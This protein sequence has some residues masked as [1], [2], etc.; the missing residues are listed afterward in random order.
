MSYQQ[1][2]LKTLS[3]GALRRFGLGQRYLNH[4]T[5]VVEGGEGAG[6]RLRLPQN[7]DYISGQSEIPVQRELARH[8]RPG[9]VVYDIGANVGFFSLIAGRLVGRAGCVYSFE[10]VAENAAS[11]CENVRLN[12]LANVT[13][14]DVAVGRSSGTAEL[15]LTDWDGGS[16]LSTSAVKPDEPISK[17]TVQVVALDDLVD[18]EGLRAPTFVKI[19]VE[20]VE[21]DVLMGMSRTIASSKPILLYE[22]DDGNNDSF[23]RRWAELDAYVTEFGYKV[24]HLKPSYGN[25]GWNVGHSL[26]IPHESPLIN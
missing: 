8:V 14:F 16:S 1:L 21:L 25:V 7:G 5:W 18:R 2:L 9:D 6:L 17:R 15:L 24:A 11:T 4:R 26:A 12:N 13:L 10:P 19:D 23:Q 22:L 20:G 3:S